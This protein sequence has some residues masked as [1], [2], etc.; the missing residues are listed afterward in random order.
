MDTPNPNPAPTP[1][2][3]PEGTEAIRLKA[4]HY[5]THGIPG[6]RFDPARFEAARAAYGASEPSFRDFL[7]GT[8]ARPDAG[9]VAGLAALLTHE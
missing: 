1:T 6:A 9:K 7:A 4:L 2:P 3:T 8:V 5:L